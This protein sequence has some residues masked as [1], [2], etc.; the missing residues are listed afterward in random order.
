MR[1]RKGDKG[2]MVIAIFVILIVVAL[3]AM[4]L[5]RKL[6]EQVRYEIK[7]PIWE[8]NK[9]LMTYNALLKSNNTRDHLIY[10]LSGNDS[11]DDEIN[12]TLNRTFPNRRAKIITGEKTFTNAVE[13]GNS[14]ANATRVILLPLGQKEDVKLKI[15]N[16]PR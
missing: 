7:Q 8:P 16:E 1:Y 6:G 12:K 4:I 3:M 14:S 5:G 9:F 10:S 15:W 11:F 13:K 2:Q